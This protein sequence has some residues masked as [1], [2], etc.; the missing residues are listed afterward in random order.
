MGLRDTFKTDVAKET[1]GVWIVVSTNEH[2]NE[3]IEIKIARMSRSNKPYAKGLEAATRPHSAAIQN[4]TLDNTVGVKI[5][6]EVF[7]DTI[8]LDWKNLPKSDLTGDDKDTELLPFTRANALALF[9][10]LPD[11]YDDWEGRAKKSANFREAE[12]AKAAKN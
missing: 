5:M 9:A 1:A 3:P 8:L 12:K 7:V 2:N 11:M 4:E 10:E 6:Q